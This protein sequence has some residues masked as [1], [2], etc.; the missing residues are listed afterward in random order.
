MKPSFA[1]AFSMSSFAS[2]LSSNDSLAR[3]ALNLT[4]MLSL[5]TPFN[6]FKAPSI[7]AIHEGHE[8]FLKNTIFMCFLSCFSFK[9]KKHQKMVFYTNISFIKSLIYKYLRE[10]LLSILI[11]R[12][13]LSLQI[14][15]LI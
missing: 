6:F 8:Y 9:I 14:S 4:W 5:S 1:I 7:F 10:Y 13:L 15:S 11:R 3:L 12:I 2:K